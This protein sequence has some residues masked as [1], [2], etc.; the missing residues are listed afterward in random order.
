MAS[1]GHPKNPL[2]TEEIRRCCAAPLTPHVHHYP[3]GGAGQ[4]SRQRDGVF[5]GLIGSLSD[6][7]EHRVGGVSELR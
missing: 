1:K 3:P 6:V 4:Y 5:D 2:S 7:R